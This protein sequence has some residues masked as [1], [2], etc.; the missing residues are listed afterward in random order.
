[1]IKAQKCS[2]VF[3]MH[4]RGKAGMFANKI[5]ALDGKEIHITPEAIRASKNL[6]SAEFLLDGRIIIFHFQWP[7]AELAHVNILRGIF[8]PTFPA[9]Q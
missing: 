4:E 1:M 8:L 5:G 6:F 2:K 9:D 3:G 7:E